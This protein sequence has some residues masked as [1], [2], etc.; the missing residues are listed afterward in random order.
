MIMNVCTRPISACRG[1]FDKKPAEAGSFISKISEALINKT[2]KPK[3]RS[4]QKR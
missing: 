2:E 3:K 4:C 1:G